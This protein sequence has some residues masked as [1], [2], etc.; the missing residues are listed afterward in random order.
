M[1]TT[2]TAGTDDESADAGGGKPHDEWLA[3]ERAT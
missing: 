2:I 1:S 3:H